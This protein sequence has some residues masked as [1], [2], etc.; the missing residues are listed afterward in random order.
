MII[1]HTI[2]AQVDSVLRRKEFWTIY[3]CNKII[4]ICASVS[5]LDIN[6]HKER[7]TSR[8]KISMYMKEIFKDIVIENGRMS[9]PSYAEIK[10]FRHLS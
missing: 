10:R 3:D 8:R 2:Y 7:K 4:F 5:L 9:V 6:D 1:A